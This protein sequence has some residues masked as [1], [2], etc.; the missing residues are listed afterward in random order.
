MKETPNFNVLT[1]SQGSDLGQDQLNE[2][3]QKGQAKSTKKVT[4]WELK[5][6]W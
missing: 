2:I 5:K 3:E 1:C 4:E 6:D